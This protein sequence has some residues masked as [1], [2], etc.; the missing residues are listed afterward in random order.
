MFE[1]K[2]K[3]FKSHLLERGYPEKIIQMTPLEVKFEERL[4]ALQPKSKENKRVLPFVATYQQSVP[5]LKQILTKKWHLLEQQPL[6]SQVY[7]DPPLISY[8]R[9]RWLNGVLVRAKL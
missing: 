3:I 7:R 8:K 6:L 5:D 1:G 2:I 4:L 9:G